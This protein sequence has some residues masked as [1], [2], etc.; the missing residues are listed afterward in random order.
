MADPAAQHGP[1]ADPASAAA[2]NTRRR[3]TLRRV[4][5][6][7]RT[8][9][10]VITIGGLG[11]IVAVLGMLVFLAAEVVPLFGRGE[12]TARAQGRA[13]LGGVPVFT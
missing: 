12:V 3:A 1:A 6:A 4:R 11:V 13:D 10:M 2:R 8:A 5:L 9:A 7:D